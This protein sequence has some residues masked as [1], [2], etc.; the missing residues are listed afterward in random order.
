MSESRPYELLARFGRDGKVAGVSVRTITT[1]GARDYESDPQPLAGIA[2]PAFADFASQFSA[3]A[4]AECESLRASLAT[5]TAER[6]TLTGQVTSQQ[7]EI[8]GLRSQVTSLATI[9]AERDDLLT[10]VPKP[11]G[12]REILP[13][14]L[15]ER[16]TV[17]QVIALTTSPDPAAIYARTLL[18]T[19][20]SPID[21]D[22]PRFRGL[23]ESLI[24]AKVFTAEELTTLLG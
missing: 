2:D 5:I 18:Q 20:T 10:R 14:E 9:T 19:R 6:D 7:S 11:R 13:E 16:L 8:D 23:L 4:A 15:I 21:L 22:S 12:P 3:A 24:A 17:P 1:V